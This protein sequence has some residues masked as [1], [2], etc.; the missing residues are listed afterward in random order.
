M[1]LFALGLN[2]KAVKAMFLEPALYDAILGNSYIQS[3]NTASGEF[4]SDMDACGCFRAGGSHGGEW[5]LSWPNSS[6]GW[7]PTWDNR[8]WLGRLARDKAMLTEA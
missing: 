2:F 3:L 6:P 5:K 1:F 4:T 8:T 7:L